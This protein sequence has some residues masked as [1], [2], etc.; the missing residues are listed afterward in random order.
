MRL[1][2]AI[3]IPDQWKNE[4]AKYEATFS[5]VK[6]VTWVDKKNLHVTLFFI[7][8]CKEDDLA[9]LESTL[10]KTFARVEPFQLKFNQVIW[11]PPKKKPPHMI[12]ALL[13]D[14]QEFENLESQIYQGL[15]PFSLDTKELRRPANPHITIA[16]IKKPKAAQQ[17]KIAQ[18]EL[19]NHVLAI[20]KIQLIAS[21]LTPKGPHYK[22]MKDF[23]L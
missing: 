1:F 14:S 22:T 15:K 4:L 12:W 13:N 23:S 21:T 17:I 7:G 20:E 6:G 3:P 5:D 18:P 10:A 11:A 8:E 16:R 2:L 19:E 9:N